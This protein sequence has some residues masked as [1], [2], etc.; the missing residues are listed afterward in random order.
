MLNSKV[1]AFKKIKTN[2]QV[3]FSL[4]AQLKH[5]RKGCMMTEINGC[6]QNIKYNIMK[7]AIIII[8]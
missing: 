5:Q 7:Y 6:Q 1:S 3:I 8:K 4:F 2:P